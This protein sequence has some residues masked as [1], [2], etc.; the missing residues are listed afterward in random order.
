VLN[1]VSQIVSIF[2][3]SLHQGRWR[4]TGGGAEKID[5]ASLKGTHGSKTHLLRAP[6]SGRIGE[7]GARERVGVRSVADSNALSLST[8][9][10][11]RVEAADGPR[12]TMGI[13]ISLT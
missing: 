11:V 1:E 5:A 4:G 13:H 3:D 12:C 7:R 6:Q 9:L 2:R 10:I 8:R